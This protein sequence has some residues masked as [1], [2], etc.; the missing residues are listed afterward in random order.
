M[1]VAFPYPVLFGDVT[2]RVLSARVDGDELPYTMISASD[3]TVALHRS[4]RD[5]W[6]RARLR[7]AVDFPQGELAEGPWS[8]VVF[9]AVLSEKST[10][11]RTTAVLKRTDDGTVEGTVELD[12]ARH[13]DRVTLAVSVVATVG[14]V[15]GRLIGSTKDSWYVDLRASAPERRQEIEIVEADFREGEHEWLRAYQESAWVVDTTGDMPTVYLNTGSVEGLMALLHSRG[16][17]P[18][19]RA[20]RDMTHSMIAQ[21]AWIAMF[22]SAAGDL[23]TDE[24]GTPIMPSGWREAVLRSMLPDVL[25]GQQPADALHE[26]LQRREKGYGWAEL[27]TSVQFAAGRRSRNTR[28]LTT[29]V[30]SLGAAGEAGEHR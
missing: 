9:L 19:E 13:R 18:S 14:D 4:G 8:D 12:R 29:A 1:T 25:P 24:D 10:N 16:G 11:A 5:S 30:R 3:G 15:S 7:V 2:V 20:F 21:D 23:D 27:Q 28:H 6:E 26:I 17:M 22:H